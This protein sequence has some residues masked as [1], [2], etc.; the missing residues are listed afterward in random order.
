[1]VSEEK[2]SIFAAENTCLDNVGLTLLDAKFL[3]LQESL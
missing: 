3:L 2:L 1:M